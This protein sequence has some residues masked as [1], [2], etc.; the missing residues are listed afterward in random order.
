MKRTSWLSLNLPSLP[1][2]HGIPKPETEKGSRSCRW[3]C[4]VIAN[5][6]EKKGE[7]IWETGNHQKE[8]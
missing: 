2:D 7:G 4:A 5:D 6:K 1:D 8:M 3:V